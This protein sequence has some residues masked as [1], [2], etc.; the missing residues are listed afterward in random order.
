MRLAQRQF[1]EHVVGGRGVGD[2]QNESNPASTLKREPLI[3]LAIQIE[4]HGLAN[5][6]GQNGPYRR[7]IDTGIYGANGEDS[8]GW[9]RRRGGLGASAGWSHEAGSQRGDS[10]YIHGFH[11]VILVTFKDGAAH[12]ART[13]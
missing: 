11:F 6:H 9:R 1:F 5:F 7:W 10:K 4:L 12:R 2:V 8:R 13:S 3:D